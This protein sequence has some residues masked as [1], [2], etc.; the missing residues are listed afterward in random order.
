MLMRHGEGLMEPHDLSSLEVVS[1]V[2]EPF[3][4]EAWHWTHETLGKG[5]ICVNNTWGQTELAGCP[6]AGA[7]WLTPMKPVVRRAVSRR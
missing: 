4:P 2:G 6:L 3:N 1:V 5:R 7:A